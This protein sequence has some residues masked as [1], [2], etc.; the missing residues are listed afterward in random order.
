MELPVIYEEM[1]P[2]ERRAVREEY[3]RRQDGKCYWCREPL[4]GDPAKH[5]RTRKV[6]WALFPPNFRKHPVHLQHDHKTG[7]T[8][9]AVHMRCNAVMW[10]FH[11]R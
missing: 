9:G 8:E 2:A 10:Q 6:T 11:G 4:S 3:V 1:P 7:L 5:I